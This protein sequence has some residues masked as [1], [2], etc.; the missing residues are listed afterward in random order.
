MR[1]SDPLVIGLLLRCGAL[2]AKLRRIPLLGPCLSWVGHRF[3]P[4]QALVW[5]RVQNG[6]GKGIW[7][8]L[9]PRT[10]RDYF[11]G[12]IEPEVQKALRETFR[13][14]M[15][16]YDVGASIGFYSLLGARLAGATGQVYS[17]EADPEIAARLRENAGRNEAG[18][19]KV[20]EMAA[21]SSNGQ[22]TFARADV[23]LSP[24]RGLGHVAEE[25]CGESV[26]VEAI[27]LDRFAETHPLPQVIKLDVEGA[28]AEVL[29]GGANVFEKASPTLICE[30]HHQR[31]CDDVTRWLTEREYGIRWLEAGPGFPRHLLATK[32]AT[33]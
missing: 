16:F 32:R 30:V 17:F 4:R 9:N 26:V 31:A 14:A 19:V 24:D 28:E 3:V 25:P 22:V 12:E 10:G 29:K 20:V 6:P 27:T 33:Q 8:R 18:N 1:R 2:F 21:W 7:L 5:A 15:I 23:A 13:E 11:A